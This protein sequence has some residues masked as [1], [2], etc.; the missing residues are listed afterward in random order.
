MKNTFFPF[1]RSS[2]VNRFFP[3][4][5]SHS[6]Q[7]LLQAVY[8]DTISKL[9][10]HLKSLSK[11]STALCGIIQVFFMMSEQA[12]FFQYREAR[13]IIKAWE[14]QMYMLSWARNWES[15]SRYV[16]F[17]SLL[18]E[19]TMFWRYWAYNTI[20]T[21]IIPHKAV[22]IFGWPFSDGFRSFETVSS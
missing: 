17:S 14:L 4:N 6:L 12:P 20:N 8:E 19:I 18:A 5:A 10:N 9:Q 3:K 21:W 2:T 16:A 7:L 13:F 1:Q 11:I 22:E 15:C